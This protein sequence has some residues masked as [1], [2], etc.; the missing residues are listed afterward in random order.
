MKLRKLLETSLICLALT[1]PLS[2][3]GGDDDT[4]TST[5]NAEDD[6]T[7]GESTEEETGPDM[8]ITCS[9]LCVKNTEDCQGVVFETDAQCQEACEMWDADSREC[10]YQQII[11][12]NCDQVGDMGPC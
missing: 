1:A 7:T 11:D 9:I 12:G 10:R 4:D 5:T 2:A 3:C 6:E 8:E